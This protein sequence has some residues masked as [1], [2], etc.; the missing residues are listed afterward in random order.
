MYPNELVEALSTTNFSA[1]ESRIVNFIIRKTLGWQKLTDGIGMGLIEKE[2]GINRSDASR[3]LKR[4][5][6]RKII[7]NKKNRKG[8]GY[9]YNTLGINLNVH[10]WI[11]D[12]KG[13]R[14]FNQHPK[15]FKGVCK[16]CRGC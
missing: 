3:V 16:S 4:L 9:T 14:Q 15:R 10:Q 5:R 11:R 12:S 8:A 1:Y 2:I 6:A 13:C 7:T